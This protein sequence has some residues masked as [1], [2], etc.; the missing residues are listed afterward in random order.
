MEVGA[1]RLCSTKEENPPFLRGHATI[2]GNSPEPTLL[3]NHSGQNSQGGSGV[4]VPVALRL[5]DHLG[6]FYLIITQLTF[7][8]LPREGGSLLIE[9]LNFRFLKVTFQQPGLVLVPT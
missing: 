2:F 8:T 5:K 6:L 3:E 4:G 1:H 9:A 7:I